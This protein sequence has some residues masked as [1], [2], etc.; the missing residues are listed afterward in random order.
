MKKNEIIDLITGNAL[1]ERFERI[2]SNDEEIKAK[3][4]HAMQVFDKLLATF[5]EEQKELFD[6]FTEA[7]AEETAR[8]EFLI[9]QQ[10][11]KDM[12]NLKESLQDMAD[13][14]EGNDK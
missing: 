1:N 8:R 12:Y 3:R 7:D 11:L 2:I 6:W 4:I 10:G 9:Y 5:S 14:D 13:E